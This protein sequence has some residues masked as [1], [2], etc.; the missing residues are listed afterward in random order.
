MLAMYLTYPSLVPFS[1]V[2]RSSKLRHLPRK[3][4]LV[5]NHARPLEHQRPL[6]NPPSLVRQQL[7]GISIKPIQIQHLALIDSLAKQACLEI[8]RAIGVRAVADADGRR[9]EQVLGIDLGNGA[10]EAGLDGGDAGEVGQVAGVVCS[11]GGGEDGG[12]EAEVLG[13]DG[14]GVG[15]EGL[16]DL[17][18]GREAGGHAGRCGGDGGQC[19]EEAEQ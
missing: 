15:V 2:S 1:P 13:V 7:Q 4:T 5:P 10:G 12:E 14:K 9:A 8:G 16:V 3:N 19:R 18:P 6:L 17:L 11:G